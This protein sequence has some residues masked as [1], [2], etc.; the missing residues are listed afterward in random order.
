MGSAAREASTGQPAWTHFVHLVWS[1]WVFLTPAFS[2]GSYGFTVR[3]VVLTLVSYPLFVWL[4]AVSVLGS[5][6]RAQFAAF[7]AAAALVVAD[8][9]ANVNEGARMAEAAI[10]SGKA[11]ATLE[12]LISVSN[13][14]SAA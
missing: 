10:D 2:S 4:Y 1:A 13:S 7:N 6:R 14:G 11:R 8:K 12:K 5:S 9:A 3:W